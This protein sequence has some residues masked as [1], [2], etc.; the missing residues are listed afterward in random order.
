MPE[1]RVPH[2]VMTPCLPET[3]GRVPEGRVPH[4]VMTPCT[5]LLLRPLLIT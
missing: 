4:D 2:G 3:E 1:G 5:P